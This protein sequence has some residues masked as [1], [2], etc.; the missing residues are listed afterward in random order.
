[1][2]THN[3]RLQGLSGGSRESFE[4]MIAAIEKN[5]IVPVIDTVFDI[6]QTKDAFH[7]LRQKSSV[8]KVVIR[9]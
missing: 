8:G 1:M 5:D 9:I 4:R 7:Y 3:V 2:L 6:E